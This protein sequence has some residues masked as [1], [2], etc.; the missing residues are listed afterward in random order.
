[1]LKDGLLNTT[2]VKTKKPRV[3]PPGKRK[4]RKQNKP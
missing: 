3:N 4:T 1:M 2:N